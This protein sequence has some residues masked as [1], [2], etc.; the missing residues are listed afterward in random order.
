MYNFFVK[1][2]IA[3]LFCQSDILDVELF[4]CIFQADKLAML[5][6]FFDMRQKITFLFECDHFSQELIIRLTM[7][8]KICKGFPDLFSY[9][10]SLV[11][12]FSQYIS[13][14]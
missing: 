14:R 4:C 13:L 6:D 11:C 2:I 12:N 9:G 8:F 5:F 1:T 10:N 7:F 3:G